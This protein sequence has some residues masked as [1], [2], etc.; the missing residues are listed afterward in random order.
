MAGSGRKHSLVIYRE[1]LNRWWP[2]T[3]VL[4][5]FLVTLAWP[6]YND[7]LGKIQSWRWIGMLAL[8]AGT[9]LFS[10]LLLVMRSMAYVQVFPAYLKLVTPF[11]RLN[12]SH[13]RLRRSTTTEMRALFPPEKMRGWKR[14]VIAPLG[15]RTAVVLELNGW[16]AS[17]ELL[18]VFLSYFFFKDKMPHFV[19]LVA[20]WMRFS[21]E[22]ESQRRG[23]A[24]APSRQ[25]RTYD[26]SILSRLPPK[27]S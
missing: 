17:S 6:V 27:D 10:L 22:L 24:A 9:F 19:I 4:G 11:L 21:T 15:G 2:E 5:F 26:P 12:I 25:P 8:G 7:P 23:D 16:P 13:K 1:V 3:M 20:D 18:H 14:N